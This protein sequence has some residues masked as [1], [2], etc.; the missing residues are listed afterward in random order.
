MNI[1][2]LQTGPLG[3][4]TYIVPCSSNDTEKSNT[5]FVV[6]PGGDAS[7]I[8]DE[9]KKL[10]ANL[11]AIVLTHGH[12]DHVGGLASLKEMYPNAKICIHKD[13]NDYIG[14]K[15]YDT[16]RKIFSS[17]GYQAGD[18]FTHD[19]LPECELYLEDN[20]VLE[21]ASDWVV[22]HTPG[23]TEGSICL[24][25][26]NEKILLSGDTLFFRSYGRTDLVGGSYEKIK[27]SLQRL[28]KLPVE[29]IVFSGHEGSTTIDAEKDMVI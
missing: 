23:H 14:S 11:V 25:N 13:D 2:C 21:F 18:F 3:A 4:N 19:K 8:S 16:H 9:L 7:V 22:L 1:V 27:Q 20:K 5:V 29:T 12:F 24:Y 6:D 26:E 28:F 17:I 10:N 15:G